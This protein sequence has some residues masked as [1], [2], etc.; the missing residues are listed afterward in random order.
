MKP[1]LT[2]DESVPWRGA[3]LYEYFKEGQ[4][5]SPTVLAARTAT[6]KLIKYPGHDDWT[7][8]FDLANDPYETKNLADDVDLLDTLQAVFDEQSK[9][10]EFRMP[11]NVGKTREHPGRRERR[12]RQRARQRAAEAET[13]TTE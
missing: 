8:L 12:N 1:L 13:T 2:N 5:A 7:E 4:F 11:E 10:V 3:F 6:H 9:A